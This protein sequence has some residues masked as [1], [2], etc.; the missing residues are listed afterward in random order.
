MMRS[1]LMLPLSLRKF[2]VLC[3]FDLILGSDI[4]KSQ[5]LKL[6]LK[7]VEAENLFKIYIFWHISWIQDTEKRNKRM[8]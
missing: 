8:S 4:L 1:Y 3:N 7:I 6:P 5:R 2:S